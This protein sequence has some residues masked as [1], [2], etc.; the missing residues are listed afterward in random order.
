MR[1]TLFFVPYY[2]NVTYGLSVSVMFLYNYLING[3]VFGYSAVDMK[4]VL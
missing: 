1:T 4:C 2:V 3:I